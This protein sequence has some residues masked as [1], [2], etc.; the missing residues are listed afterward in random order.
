MRTDQT[1]PIAG[2]ALLLAG[3]KASVPLERLPPLLERAQST[4][5]ERRDTYRSRYE[6]VLNSEESACFLVEAGHWASLGAELGFTERET[7]A[8]R[9]AHAEHLLYAGRREDRE[10]EFEAALDL[11]EAVV[12]G[13]S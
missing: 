12:V 8:V 4:L 3:A 10:T 11:R 6:C 1:H 5:C 2:P 13:R 9:R 7:D